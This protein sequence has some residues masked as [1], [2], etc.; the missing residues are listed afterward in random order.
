[1]GNNLPKYGIQAI[2]DGLPSFQKAMDTVQKAID[3][4]GK[5]AEE[6]ARKVP[7]F[8][9]A[10]GKAGVS[11]DDLRDKLKGFIQDNVPFGNALSG[12]VDKLAAIPLPA[13]AAAAAVVGIGV[14]FI[15]LGERG[16]ALTGVADSFDRLAASVNLNSKSLLADLRAASNGTI[17]DFDLIKGANNAL[18][19]QVGEFGQAF[20]RSLPKLLEVA[21]ASARAT[22]QDVNFLYESIVT[23][24]KRGSP[25]ILDNLGI[26]VNA[27]AANKKYAESIGVSAESLTDE[28]KKLAYLN[29]TL[30]AGAKIVDA[31]GNAHETAAEKIARNQTIITNILDGFAVAVQPAYETVLDAI[32]KVLNIFKQLADAAAPIFGALLSVVATD[33]STIVDVVT[34]IVQPII[35]AISSIAP[36]ISLAFQFIAKVIAL[37]G[38]DIGNI[39]GGIVRFLSDVAKNFFGLDLK[40]L[41]PQLFNGAAAAFGSFANGII[42]VANKLI[43]PA[44]IGIAKFIAD[45][46]IGFSPPKKGPL[47]VIDKGG[48]NIM[49]AWLGGFT[50]V[51]LDPVEQVAKQVSDALGDIGKQSLVTVNKRLAQLDKSLLP[52]QQRLDIVKANFESLAEPAK[53]ALDAIDRQTEEAQ[54]ALAQGDPAAAERL[55]M[56]DQQRDAIQGQLD[57]QQKIVD[58][59]TV[60]LALAKAQ[61]APERALLT[62][63]Q[64][65]L[66]AI[67]K[68]QGKAPASVGGSGGTLPKEEKEKK[69]SGA[70][71]TPQSG[72]GGMPAL[73]DSA[74]LPNV[75]D[76]IGGQ[77]SV[78]E[79]LQGLQDAFMGQID[80]GNLEEFV[81]NSLDL[82]TQIDRIKGVDI[83]SKIQDKFKGL[84]DA[85]DP[86]NPDSIPAKITGF[87]NTLTAGPEVEGS[88]AHLFSSMGAN[89]SSTAGTIKSDV[90][91]AL[92]GI[93]NPDNPDSAVANIA[94]FVG[95][96]SGGVDEDG[97]IA[98]FF[99]KLPE[100]LESAKPAILA[101]LGTFATDLFDPNTEGSPANAIVKLVGA[102]TGDDSQ[103]GKIAEYFAGLP[104]RVVAA[105]GTLLDDI[106]TNIFTPISEFLTGN[107]PG[108]MGDILNQFVTL[109]TNLPALIV[110]ALANLGGMVYN[111]V[112]VPVINVLNAAIGAI[113]TGIRNI[114][115]F[116]ANQLGQIIG[117][118]DGATI[119]GTNL[120]GLIPQALRDFQANLASAGSNFTIGR[121]SAELPSFLAPPGGAKGGLL[122]EGLFK[123]GEKGP[124]YLFSG[125]RFGVLPN[126]FTR[127]LDG[128]TQVLAQPAALPVM[129]GNTY[130]NSDS[131]V[132]NFY[133]VNSPGDVM[134]RMAMLRAGR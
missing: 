70:E 101:S 51:S 56:L 72:G 27:T 1:M 46:L 44:V 131:M 10:L 97:S 80:T 90:Q 110:A 121:I 7:S 35:D 113:E 132:N 75:L 13:L 108:S 16:A 88:I 47:S 37:V 87:V 50:G 93:F 77:G 117:G 58:N 25:L 59:S 55:R 4:A 64:A 114:A 52:F 67:A 54:A 11:V 129:A 8:N 128:L 123:V 22:G 84:T 78:D 6:A 21:R 134:R 65:Y 125:D 45:F 34:S 57:A 85:F 18:V 82:G 53:A 60:Q 94:T 126:E 23:G 109:W 39:V 33:F 115:S 89:I 2:V 28:Q 38:K 62:I 83:G 66:Q 79:A 26:L 74:Q 5:K 105:A 69:G 107:Q 3:T 24:I 68:A 127:V 49:K 40:N 19:G 32:T 73:P 119:A 111:A 91:T 99:A 118:F 102:L 106:K 30:E 15:K 43:F 95:R 81:Q 9:S 86:A 48:E 98:S 100:N 63:R 130:N 20:G 120:G 29:A 133:G 96:L 14:A 103:T 41:G 42:A 124:E 104:D 112:V 76:L 12:I 122:G 61:Q 17:A 92:D 36:Y 116:F 71:Q 31:M